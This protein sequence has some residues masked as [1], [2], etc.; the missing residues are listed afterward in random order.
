[1]QV[2]QSSSELRKHLQPSHSY[3][4][5]HDHNTPLHYAA[6]H[7]M[8]HLVRAFLTDLD[9]GGDPNRR[10]G[11]GQTALHCACDVRR[12]AQAKSPSAL[13]RRGYSV[14]LLLS[15]RGPVVVG[16][17][18]DGGAAGV[19]R[20]RVDVNAQD[21]FGLTATHYAARS[22]LKKCLDYLIAHGADVFV[23]DREGRTPCDLAL[24]E[25]HHH[26]AQALESRMVFSG[27]PESM[28]SVGEDST[29]GGGGIGQGAFAL[30]LGGSVGG[31]RASSQEDDE[32]ED[33][34]EEGVY[35]G[36]RA[37][38]L[39]EAKE[40]LLVETSE[41]LRVPLFSAEALLRHA[42]WSREYLLQMWSRDPVGTCQGA[43]VQV[44]PSLLQARQ[45]LQEQQQAV[46][47]GKSVVEVS[48]PRQPL[49]HLQ[50]QQQFQR[51]TP[52]IH[53]E[54]SFIVDEELEEEG[55]LCEICCDLMGPTSAPS[56]GGSEETPPC[57]HRICPRCWT[58]HLHTRWNLQSKSFQ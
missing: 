43:G 55:L 57:G 17:D 7:G 30:A 25:G 47:H 33:E 58:E 50:E 32:E 10:N 18:A 49:H 48:K 27:T 35:C 28:A 39:Q 54:N 2:Y 38:D 4:E 42:E 11:M 14:M 52:K 44:P 26:I 19:E 41:M 9:P 13:E 12:P 6:R 8:K 40:Q 53:S 45:Q 46:V 3:G 37:Q 5:H 36:L 56:G 29:G 22:G 51:L 23:E 21:R 31:I 24:R 16:V 20:Q 1:M 34:D 15:W